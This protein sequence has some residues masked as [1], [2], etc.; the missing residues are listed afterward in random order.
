VVQSVSV[1]AKQK[2]ASVTFKEHT[3]E[4]EKQNGALAK[5]CTQ[6]EAAEAKVGAIEDQL[7]NTM[8][9]VKKL[10]TGLDLTQEYWKGLFKGL[11]ETNR[12]M[13]SEG[14][15]LPSKGKHIMVLPPIGTRPPSRAPPTSPGN[16]TVR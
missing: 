16:M 5:T 8:E 14:E 4:I 3:K 13:N 2:A 9:E 15:V 10:T 1:T 12:S 11:K 6:V 7:K